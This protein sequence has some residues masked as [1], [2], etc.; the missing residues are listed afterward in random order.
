MANFRAKLSDS[1]LSS[2]PVHTLPAICYMFL[3]LSLLFHTKHQKEKFCNIA[4]KDLH[5]RKS[6]PSAPNARVKRWA[7]L[8]CC[9][10]DQFVGGN[11]GY[12]WGDECPAGK[13]ELDSEFFC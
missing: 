12:H 11:C 4:S 7:K 1:S 2:S 13:V 9:V 8:C 3:D 5:N 10:D 6:K